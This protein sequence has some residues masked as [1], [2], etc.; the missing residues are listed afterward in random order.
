MLIAAMTVR[1]HAP[2]A[3]SLKEKRME[4]RSLLARVRSR[5][6]ISA[7]EVDAQDAHQTIV[8]GIAA[9]AGDAAQADSILDH[10]IRYIEGSTQA[11]VMEIIRE[12]R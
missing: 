7:A 1:L 10:V 2:W 12:M 6:N 4:V 3:H 8:L 9:V 11:E 5:F